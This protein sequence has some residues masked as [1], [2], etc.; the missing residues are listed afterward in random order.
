L[1]RSERMR[2]GEYDI[3]ISEMARMVAHEAGPRGAQTRDEFKRMA[4]ELGPDITARQ[5]D[6]LAYREDRWD[7]LMSIP[8]PVLCL[9][10][11]HDQFSP[12]ADGQ[13]LAK[14]V[15]RGTYVELPACG[16]FPTL[17]Y[18]AETAEAIMTWHA[19]NFT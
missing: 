16:H 4:R 11:A 10:G 3:V 15:Q 8:T 14:S 17:E 9:W 1:R 12:A 6:A 2:G 5:S 18:P 7:D 19:R 13:R